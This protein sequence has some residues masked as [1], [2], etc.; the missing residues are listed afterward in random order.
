MKLTEALEE[1]RYAIN[2]LS[3]RTQEWYLQKVEVFVK[4]C[5]EQNQTEVEGLRGGHIRRF[6]QAIADAP[7]AHNGKPLTTYTINGYARAVRTF[8]NW[9]N[10]EGISVNPTIRENVEM[11]TVE[12][13]VI[14][15]FTVDQIKALL[16]ATKYEYND[17]LTMRDK[18]I[19]LTLTETGIRASELCGLTLENVFL[20]PY[21]A[22]L[23]VRGKGQKEREV[24][25]LGNTARA[26]LHRYITRYRKAP[27]EEQHVFLNRSGDPMTK[28]G[29]DQTLYR[30]RDWAKVTGVRCSAHTFRHTYAVNYL[31]R[32]GD[33]FKLMRLMGHTNVA[34][35]EE[36]LK[37]FKQRDARR[38]IGS[39]VDSW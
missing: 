15:V 38:D 19:I 33:V 4:W 39:F 27:P 30:L 32:G 11:P 24:G 10:K 22:H 31:R 9:C 2:R 3:P 26:T 21:D 6:H 7:N 1:Y 17:Y 13:K 8:L 29:L 5:Q 35:T 37:A 16:A 20:E 18:A 36:Y 12:E 14:E 34:V 28:S 23:K 25:P